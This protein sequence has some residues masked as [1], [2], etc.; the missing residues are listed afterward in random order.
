MKPA[1]PQLDVDGGPVQRGFSSNLLNGDVVEL[2]VNQFARASI[3]LCA[4]SRRLATL[5]ASRS[6]SP[7]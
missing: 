6:I 7:S 5:V 4:Y 2:R 3:T 1:S